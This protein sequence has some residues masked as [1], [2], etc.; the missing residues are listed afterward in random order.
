MALTDYLNSDAVCMDLAPRERDEAIRALLGL[1][2][3]C[4]ALSAELADRALE[5]ILEREALGSTAI[6]RGL[7]VPHG[8]LEGLGR[9][10]VALGFSSSGVEFNA[11]DGAPVHQIFLIIAPTGQAE[12]YLDAMERVTRLVQNA[13]FRR[14]VSHAKSSGEVLD[15]I[16]EMDV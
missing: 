13:D 8:R 10:M 2:V 15:L 14:F 4:K 3:A 11:L 1:L 9:I 5:A 7:A 12:D 6:G 16:A